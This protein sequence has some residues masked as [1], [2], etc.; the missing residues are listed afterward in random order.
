MQL[1]NKARHFFWIAPLVLGVVFIGGGIF[2]ISE[3]RAAHDEVRDSVIREDI[4]VS[5]DSPVFGGEV[6]DSAAK[7]QA[8]SDVILAHTNEA[9][10]GLTYATLDRFVAADGVGTTSDAKLALL[11]DAGAPVENPLRATALT[12]ATLR[13]SL[14]VAVMGF[15]ISDLVSGLGLFM[16]AIGAT[17]I[18][19]LAPATY[20]AA[21]MANQHA[22]ELEKRHAGGTKTAPQPV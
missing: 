22:D 10:G 3:G 12:S 11:N 5:G 1:F 6:I 15:R 16:M 20:Y 21:Q 7:A 18:L 4:T 13:T 9:T 8:Q 2:M 19:F 17:Y 14:G